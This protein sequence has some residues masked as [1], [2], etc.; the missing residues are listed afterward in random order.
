[1]I[2]P[3]TKISDII[4][5]VVDNPDLSVEDAVLEEFKKFL[6]E[7]GMTQEELDTLTDGELMVILV[8]VGNPE[9][10][11]VDI[12][13]SETTPEQ[14]RNFLLSQPDADEEEINNLTDE[15]LVEIREILLTP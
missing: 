15:E 6:L 1:M 9:G 8:E 14:V 4:E 5:D 10:V 7:N 2:T 11:P 12:L 3:K 13:N